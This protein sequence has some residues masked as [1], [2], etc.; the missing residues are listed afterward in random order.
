MP[1]Y[2]IDGPD[3]KTYS[4]DGPPG[5]TQE[6]VI[7][8]IK[9]AQA[10]A[11]KDTSQPS[12]IDRAVAYPVGR[13]IHDIGVNTVSGMANMG[14]RGLDIFAPGM[15]LGLMAPLTQQAT[16]ITDQPY[17][18]ALARNRNTP[19][20]AAA[21]AQADK[22]V[23]ARTAATPTGGF[24]D[25]MAAPFLPTLAGI[26]GL[27]GG[28]DESNARA[29]AQAQSQGNFAA[30]NP[31][32]ATGAGLLGGF[33]VG[34]SGVAD[35]VPAYA[36]DNPVLTRMGKGPNFMG[37]LPQKPTG[38]VAD[39]AINYVQR[40]VQSS[41]KT[42][43]DLANFDTG[44]KPYTAA[45]AIGKP[46]TVG[47]A[48]LGRREGATAD[49]LQGLLDERSAG[50]PGRIMSDYASA[51]GIDPNAAAGNMEAF[52][53]SGRANAQ[54]I[55]ERAFQ[56][57]SIAPLEDQFRTTLTQITGQKG[58]IARQIAQIERDNPGAL[59]ARGAAGA[60]VRAKY[61]DLHKQ[62]TQ[63]EAD[64][65]AA[66]QR[67][68]TAKA[69]G[70]GARAGAVWNPRI[71]QFLDD[72]IMKAGIARGLEVQ[73]LE[74]LRDGVP[75]NP[76]ELAITG[77]D[78]AGKPVVGGVPNM[79]L[80]DAGKRGLDEIINDSRDPTTGRLVMNERVKALVGVKNAYLKELD[81]INPDYALARAQAGDYLSASEAFKRGQ[82]TIL[83]PNVT[84]AQFQKSV[85]SLSPAD[86]MA[87][88]GGAANK[89]F[90]LAQNGKLDP[91]LFNRPIVQQKL[92]VLLGPDKAA[93]LL[94]NVKAEAELAANSARMRPGNLSPTK[95][96][97]AAMAEQDQGNS[98]VNLGIDAATNIAKK[99][100]VRGA[101]DTAL[102]Y[103]K[104]PIAN[105]RAGVMPVPVRDAA[106]VMLQLPPQELGLRLRSLPTLPRGNGLPK[107]IPLLPALI[108][109]PSASNR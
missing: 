83:N 107:P 61:M 57:G 13:A 109:Q 4:I 97:D 33:L 74:A 8:Q 40:L 24:T 84:V 3:G 76:Q 81:S 11:P 105:A 30:N 96:L 79:R 70:S 36:G 26:N 32:M 7:A 20:Y 80:L 91:K 34:P 14:A 58:Q 29:D 41:G 67:F 50:A 77:V 92:A 64:R 62:L 17:Q 63:L 75:F 35:A 27:P 15:G 99:G 19:G 90:N 89:L 71:Q 45:E 101:I 42:P 102:P 6:Q 43:A 108:A 59:A 103:V 95:E 66:L 100:F 16:Q 51:S 65:Q 38:P 53:Q 56:G 72:P 69:D 106:G 47:L 49:A 2:T 98:A 82:D 1:T 94:A 9:A 39:P 78:E 46:G 52:V 93:T 87:K 37:P 68:Q 18:N 22:E 10:A 55:Y 21:R 5:A 60:D 28:L 44:G 104:N 54:P 88:S 48:A 73:R 25:A 85:E 23:A 86:R 31:L 12:V